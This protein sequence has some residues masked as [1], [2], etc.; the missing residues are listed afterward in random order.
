MALILSFEQQQIIKKI[1]A[2][3]EQ[4]YNNIAS[5]I[6]E[7]ELKK[8]LGVALLQDLQNNPA[9]ENN[10]KL[11]DGDSFEN[12]NGFNIFHKGL[13]YVIAYLNYSKYIGL[14]FVN[15]TF[16]G[17]VQKNR[18][19][20]EPVSD[21]T[22]KRL[23][24]EYRSIALTE[25]ELIKQYLTVNYS[26]YPLFLCVGGKKLFT[27]Q[28]TNITKTSYGGRHTHDRCI[29]RGNNITNDTFPYTLP[30]NTF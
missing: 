1:S 11:L 22:I 26:N 21:G 18:N 4:K 28:L 25:F 2:N 10:I 8:L 29:V 30:F 13:R 19:E 16:T 17:F 5:E 27:P 14:S 7:F 24:N 15:D 12:G 20:S 23:Q 3:N 9:T 6:E